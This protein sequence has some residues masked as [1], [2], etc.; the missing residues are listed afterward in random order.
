MPSLSFWFWFFSAIHYPDVYCS[1]CDSDLPQLPNS[2]F[3]CVSPNYAMLNC[4]NLCLLI[5]ACKSV[6]KIGEI[7]VTTNCI[8][9]DDVFDLMPFLKMIYSASRLPIFK[10][11]YRAI[12]QRNVQVLPGFGCWDD[13]LPLMDTRVLLIDMVLF[14]TNQYQTIQGLTTPPASNPVQISSVLM[15]CV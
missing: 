7:E 10:Y 12:V 6:S 3:M 8:R 4:F 15:Q 14:S 1:L 9:D 13:N 11:L 2:R 5:K